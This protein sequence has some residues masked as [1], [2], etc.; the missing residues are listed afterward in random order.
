MKQTTYIVSQWF[1][2][3]VVFFGKPWFSFWTTLEVY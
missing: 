3:L 2:D 1:T